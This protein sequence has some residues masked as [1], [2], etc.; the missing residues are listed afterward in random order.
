MTGLDADERTLYQ[1]QKGFRSVSLISESGLYKLV[2]RSNKPEARAFQDWVTREVL[3]AIRKDG[4]YIKGEE[5]VATGEPSVRCSPKSSN[6]SRNP[7]VQ[8][9]HEEHPVD[10]SYQ[11]T[12]QKYRDKL[13]AV[14]KSGVF[15][16]LKNWCCEVAHGEGCNDDPDEGE[17]MGEQAVPPHPLSDYQGSRRNEKT[18]GEEEPEGEGCG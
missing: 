15:S 12:L 4:G 1:I 5:L 17:Q 8:C 10:Q 2:M 18:E 7:A 16:R 13:D 3:P 14:T 6:A 11:R 9:D